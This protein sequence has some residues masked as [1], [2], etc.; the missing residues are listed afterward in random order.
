MTSEIKE[1]QIGPG[2][3]RFWTDKK[4]RFCKM[5]AKEGAEFCGQHMQDD[6]RRK[7]V[8]C[9]SMIEDSRMAKHMKKCNIYTQSLIKPKYYNEKVNLDKTALTEEDLKFA[10][11]KLSD[12][13][14]D[15]VKS[16]VDLLKNGKIKNTSRKENFEPSFYQNLEKEI[17]SNKENKKV[18][19]HLIQQSSLLEI[20]N[21]E[22][23]LANGNCFLELGAGTGGL[24]E[25]VAEVLGT[26]QV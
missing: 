19:K 5:V 1:G 8:Y 9:K 25:K 12:F 10:S 23:L 4:K 3:C 26:L 13:S 18:L 20:M 22:G 7:C 21:K 24:S 15:E 11:M 6:L 2:G 16:I 17:E 14:L